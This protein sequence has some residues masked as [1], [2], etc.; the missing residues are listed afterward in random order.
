[1][2][3]KSIGGGEPSGVVDDDD[4]VA[5]AEVRIRPIDKAR[6]IVD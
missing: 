5:D 4:A 6:L 2:Q 3:C 1:M